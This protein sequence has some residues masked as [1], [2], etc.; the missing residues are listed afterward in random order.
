MSGALEEDRAGLY[1][2]GALNAEEMRAVRADADR[3]PALAAEIVAWER[4][5]W[6]L[7]ALVPPATPPETLWPQLEARLAR[8]SAPG[9]ALGEVYQPPLRPKTRRRSEPRAL[10]Y[11]RAT[12]LAGLAIAASLAFILVSRQPPQPPQVAM[13]MPAQPGVGGW[14]ITLRPNG[15]IHAQ[16]QGA[17]S[18]TLA[19]DFQL[20]ALADGATRPVPLGLLQVTNN[21]V[22][23]PSGLPRDKFQLL[24]SLE[25][26][27]GSPTGLPT[28]PVLFASPPITR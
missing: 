16:A 19:Q 26:K 8:L 11:W 22:L 27:G 7:V 12:A 14:L 3:D 5:L 23:K 24:V 2:L 6:P 4:R 13:I 1:V 17:L 9:Q 25:P 18:H 10:V 20:W 15:E 28:G 21:T